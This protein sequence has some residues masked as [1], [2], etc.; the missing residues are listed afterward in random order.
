MDS[1][2]ISAQAL[3]GLLYSYIEQYDLWD[4]E[5]WEVIEHMGENNNLMITIL[6]PEKT[7]DA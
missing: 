2:D 6:K 4:Y 5:V 7:Y 3:S 1:F